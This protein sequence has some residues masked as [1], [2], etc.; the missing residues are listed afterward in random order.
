MYLIFYFIY[1][2]PKKSEIINGK[3]ENEKEFSGS[4]LLKNKGISNGIPGNREIEINRGSFES[5]NLEMNRGMP[6]SFE[7]K[8]LEINRGMPG[9]FESKNLEMNRGLYGSFESKNLEINR[10][11]PRSFEP[12]N[13]EMNRGMPGSFERNHGMLESENPKIK[14]GMPVDTLHKDKTR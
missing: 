8:S 14:R 1:V 5:K 13:L 2:Q 10:G 6:G 7:S 11:I 3:Y 4:F 9:N 12:K